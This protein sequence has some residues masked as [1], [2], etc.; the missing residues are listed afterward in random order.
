MTQAELYDWLLTKGVREPACVMLGTRCVA[1]R[2]EDVSSVLGNGAICRVGRVGI[3]VL[4]EGDTWDAAFAAAKA[5]L[6]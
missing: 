4:G 2:W 3:S 5:K 1:G 6:A